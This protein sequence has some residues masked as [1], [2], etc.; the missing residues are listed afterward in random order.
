MRQAHLLSEFFIKQNISIDKIIS[1]PYLRA[2]ESIKP[3]AEKVNKDIQIDQRLQERILSDEPIDDWLEVLEHSFNDH[4]FILPGGESANDTIERANEILAMVYSDAGI[5]NTLIVSHGNLL[6][7]LFQQY[8]KRF[9]F[10]QWKKMSNPDVYVVTVK[11]E[12]TSFEHLWK[13]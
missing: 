1:S 2:V 8:D 9:G 7:L 5:T 12:N 3:F 13:S 4:N 11:D 10:K 6:A